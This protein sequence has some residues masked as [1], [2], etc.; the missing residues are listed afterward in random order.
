MVKAFFVPYANTM[1]ITEKG[2]QLY[3]NYWELKKV[4]IK[5]KY[6]IPRIDDLFD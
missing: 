2:H 1:C 4:T 3:I 6:S 5:N